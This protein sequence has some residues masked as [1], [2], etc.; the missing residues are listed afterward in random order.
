MNFRLFGHTVTIEKDE[1]CPSFK[2]VKEYLATNKVSVAG[3]LEIANK[4][5]IAGKITPQQYLELL[6]IRTE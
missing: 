4:L 3:K 2:E 1:Y 5:T 6:D